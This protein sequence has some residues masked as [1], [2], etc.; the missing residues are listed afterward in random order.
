M[1]PII[2][3][4]TVIIAVYISS[5]IIRGNSRKKRIREKYGN[6]ELAHRIINGVIWQ[7]QTSA[8]LIDSK[9]EPVDIDQ[10][11]LK[12]KAKEVWKYH[13]TGRNRFGLRITLENGVV[14]GWDEKL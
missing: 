13:Q 12:T 1:E 8:Q 10:K 11:V 4:V 9:G 6:G 14:I 5:L 3:F 7:G 2:L